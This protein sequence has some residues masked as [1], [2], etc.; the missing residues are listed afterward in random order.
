MATVYRSGLYLRLVLLG[1]DPG[2]LVAAG[3]I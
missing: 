2:A 1:G 3:L